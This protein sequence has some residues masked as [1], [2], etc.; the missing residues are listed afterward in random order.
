MGLSNLSLD[1]LDSPLQD[2]DLGTLGHYRVIDQLGKGGMGFVF[3]AEDTK[4]QRTVALKIMNRK[5]ASTPNSRA[6]FIS[7]AR[8]M[9]AVHHD[10]VATIFEVGEHNETPFMAMEML[11]GSTLEKFKNAE[12]R[13]TYKQII[14]FAKEMA[15]G[16]AAAHAQGI[17]H[18]DIKP[19]NIWI[20]SVNDRVKILDFGLAL[21]STPVDQLAGR[22]AVIG[23]PGYLSPEQARSEPLDD[24]SDL[25]SMGVVLYEL[26]TNKLPL[27]S[28][29]VAGQLIAILAHS[30]KPIRELNPDIPQPLA[31]LIHK[32]L[33]KEPRNRVRSAAELEKLLD[34]VAI[35]CESTT[36]VAQAINKLQMGLDQIVKQK[37]EPEFDAPVMMPDLPDPFASLPDDPLGS[38]GSFPAVP[39]AAPTPAANPYRK[40]QP[41]NTTKKSASSAA[42]PL[43]KYWP[44][45]LVA[46]IAVIAIPITILALSGSDSSTP[47][48]PV[49]SV[50]SVDSGNDQPTADKPTVNKPPANRSPN[51]RQAN[52]NTA[53]T[54][55]KKPKANFPPPVDV[56]APQITEA[57]VPGAIAI[58]DKSKGNGSFE[59]TRLANKAHRLTGG[60]QSKTRIPG[61]SATLKGD[62]AGFANGEPA[63]ASDGRFYLFADKNSVADISS[64]LADHVTQAGDVFRLVFDI[65][66]MPGQGKAKTR[67]T[68]LLCFKKDNKA[69]A[70]KWKL[71]ETQDDTDLRSG[72]RTVGYEYTARSEDIGKKPFVRITM[73]E[74]DGKRPKSF[75]D[76]VRLTVQ[77]PSANMASNQTGTINQSMAADRSMQADQNRSTVP[78]ASVV[79]NVPAANM[80]TVESPSSTSSTDPSPTSVE[81]PSPPPVALEVMT[82]RTTDGYGAD[83]AVKKG[84]SIRDTLGTK[85]TI[86][87]QMRGDIDI[88]HSYLRFDLTPITPESNNKN[89]NKPADIQRKT[90]KTTLVLHTTGSK[91]AAGATIR[92]HGI[93]DR[94]TS[95]W[96]ESGNR[97]ISWK[98]SYSEAG[99]GALPL[100]AEVAIPESHGKEPVVK[101]TSPELSDFV[102]TA[103]LR[104]ITLV[105]SGRSSNNQP[106]QFVAR[107]GDKETAPALQIEIVGQ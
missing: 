78:P 70:N 97:S 34:Q 55:P 46:A 94:A 7:E 59:N 61:W 37:D 73:A 63:A 3:R 75:L 36:E 54:S 47:P 18:R 32:L 72:M 52:N 65:G 76:N 21:A 96:E 5:I 10:N 11:K 81:P 102:R 60:G 8:A 16:M 93:S 66:G 20:E 28:K 45:G 14:Q 40:P 23:T 92:V 77:S 26:A 19:A 99:L 42:S 87:I 48:V 27:H 100:L 12:Q 95:S 103:P 35:D 31:D 67:Y 58:I 74:N 9:A 86:A 1:F 84:G 56:S 90:A 49:T 6:R 24:R 25:Y 82:I 62:Q 2:G 106:L 38:S 89:Q 91:P 17:V 4:L 88:Q 104:S 41:T 107:E 80:V 33:R 15:R 98:K 71:G 68:A 105:L 57:F 83:A 79:S 44:I 64:D 30:P 53:G 69:S 39:A 51:N 13:P 50:A 43:A 22:G 29:S 85:P 101:I